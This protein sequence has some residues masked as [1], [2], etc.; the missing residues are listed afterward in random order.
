MLI[1]TVFPELVIFLSFV[2]LFLECAVRYPG[3]NQSNK[4]GSHW[5]W[6][7]NDFDDGTKLLYIS[8][9]LSNAVLLLLLAV[10]PSTYDYAAIGTTKTDW[11]ILRKPATEEQN[12][13]K[14]Y[15][16]FYYC[17][18]KSHILVLLYCGQHFQEQYT[19]YVY[20][21]KMHVCKRERI[22]NKQKFQ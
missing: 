10:F 4:D 12:R 8:V 13:R 14:L 2:I 9:Q 17:S 11:Q 20:K 1:R 19:K 15:I 5:T 3:L 21:I 16:A 7:D 22:I 6:S 18:H